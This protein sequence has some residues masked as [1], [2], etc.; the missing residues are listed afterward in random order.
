MASSAKQDAER[1]VAWAFQRFA[2]P[3]A[4]AARFKGNGR[5]SAL[6]ANTSQALIRV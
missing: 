4:K 1:P 6:I 2:E 3:P 5:P